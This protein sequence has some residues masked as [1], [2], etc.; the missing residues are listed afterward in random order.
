[1]NDAI[2]SMTPVDQLW[3]LVAGALVFTMQAGFLCVEAGLSR[4][5]HSMNVA[6]KNITDY[7]FSSMAFL[8]LGFGLMFGR[9]W[10]GL[11]GT[12]DFLLG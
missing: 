12:S 9:T 3:V 5:K 11:I 7:L 8:L 4:A 10:H 6:V 2:L 1:M